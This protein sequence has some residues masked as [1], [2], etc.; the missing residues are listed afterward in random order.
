MLL[1]VNLSS[2]FKF[3]ERH[4][5][6]SAIQIPFTFERNNVEG[7]AKIYFKVDDGGENKLYTRDVVSG[8]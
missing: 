8:G 2:T 6:N 3:Y 7:T 5:S 1:Q 4:S